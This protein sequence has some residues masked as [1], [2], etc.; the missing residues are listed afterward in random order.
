VRK[1]ANIA[2]AIGVLLAAGSLIA[3]TDTRAREH[4]GRFSAGERGDPKKP[5]RVV[6]IKM[7]EGDGKMG[8]EPARIEVRRGEQV[9]FVLQNNGEED[10]EFVLATPMENRKHAEVMKRHPHMD[11]NAPNAKRVLPHANG[12]LVWKFTKRGEFEFACLIP[13]HYEKGMFGKVIVE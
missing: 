2:T 7:F 11:H 9:R 8:Y 12:E 6:N 13:G 10:H 1:S 4:H 5:A 3:A